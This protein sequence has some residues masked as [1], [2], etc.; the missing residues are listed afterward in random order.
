M[1]EREKIDKI[2]EIHSHAITELKKLNADH[3]EIIEFYTKKLEE[4]KIASLEQEL[5]DAF[6]QQ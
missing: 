2:K 1:T 5:Q 4:K 3:R 6:K